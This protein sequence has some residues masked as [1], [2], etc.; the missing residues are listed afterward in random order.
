MARNAAVITG[1]ALS[2]TVGVGYALCTL[3]FWIWPEAAAN[4]MNAL[5]HG[6]DFR[7]L[8][9]GPALFSFSSFLYALVVMMAWT[10][11][12]GA[13]YGWVQGR[14]KGGR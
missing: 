4:F 12:L 7:K 1:A 11:G 3:V 13:I 9:G 10:F 2:L 14:I 5:F 8:Q 6:L